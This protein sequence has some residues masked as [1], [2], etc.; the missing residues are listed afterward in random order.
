MNDTPDYISKK[1]LEIW[2]AKPVAERFQLALSTIDE[3]NKQTEARIKKQNPD[4]SEGELRVEFIR[5]NYKDDLT[6]EYMQ[7]VVS[8]IR[9]KYQ[10]LN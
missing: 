8:W 3:I 9:M 1:Q 2:L 4:I 5:L 7:E 10:K 6:P